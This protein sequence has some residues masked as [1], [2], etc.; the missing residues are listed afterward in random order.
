MGS[1]S[2]RTLL[3]SICSIWPRHGFPPALPGAWLPP[4]ANDAMHVHALQGCAACCE[5][6]PSQVGIAM[7][8]MSN[9]TLFLRLAKNPFPVYFNRGLNVSLS[10][11]DPLQFHH[12]HEPLLEEYN[13]A[14]QYYRLSPLDMCEIARNSVLQSGFEHAVKAYWLG[15]GYEDGTNDCGRSNVP[16]I[17]TAFRRDTLLEELQLIAHGCT[18]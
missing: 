18:K 17:R 15:R 2:I 13:M 5:A 10:T 11:D 7:S 6:P 4:G 8:P 9:N 14:A 3:C 1:L 12:T 16:N